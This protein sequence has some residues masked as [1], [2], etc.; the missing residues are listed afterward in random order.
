[1]EALEALGNLRSFAWLGTSPLLST[2]IVD[3]LAVSC[4][5]LEEFTVP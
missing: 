4:P 3:T 2:D 5:D 1:M